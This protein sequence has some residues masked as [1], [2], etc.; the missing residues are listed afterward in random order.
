MPKLVRSRRTA[1]LSFASLASALA[2][3]AAAPVATSH[4]FH[5]QTPRIFAITATVNFGPIVHLRFNANSQE[6]I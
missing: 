6:G 4:Y 2:Q 5:Y 1:R 3:D